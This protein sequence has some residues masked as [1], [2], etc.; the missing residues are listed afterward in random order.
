MNKGR[1]IVK[2]RK[3]DAHG[4]LKYEYRENDKEKVVSLGIKIANKKHFNRNTQRM[5][6]NKPNFEEIN[7]KIEDFLRKNTTYK[8]RQ[9]NNS[10]LIYQIENNV[11]SN[12]TNISTIRTYKTLAS[13]LGLFL[14]GTDIALNDID[15]NFVNRFKNYL[16][17]NYSTNSASCYFNR[18]K[19][20][21]RTI[22]LH[23]DYSFDDKIFYRNSIKSKAIEKDVLSVSE[24]QRLQNYYLCESSQRR[25]RLTNIR[26]LFLFQVLANGIR[27]SDLMTLRYSDFKIVDDEIFVDK[28]TIKNN[29]RLKFRM[30]ENMLAYV[31]SYMI[32]KED[33]D[34]ELTKRL[35]NLFEEIEYERELIKNY[36]DDVSKGIEKEDYKNKQGQKIENYLLGFTDGY[37]LNYSGISDALLL[38]AKLTKELLIKIID[39]SLNKKV[40][41]FDYLNDNLFG[42]VDD[43]SRLNDKQYYHLMHNRVIYNRHL[44]NIFKQIGVN[45]KVT[46]HT[47]RHTF[48]SL[49]TMTDSYDIME[50]SN[51]L[52]HSSIKV[53]ENY[54]HELENDKLG[55]NVQIEDMINKPIP[56]DKRKPPPN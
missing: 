17:K 46:S 43:F 36:F 48:T 35:S 53:T 24:L 4:Y 10:T 8:Q 44:K 9:S 56:F 1:I 13:R 42:D 27:L 3:K 39:T 52:T 18:L 22:Q 45:K 33:A 32:K 38:I 49:L 50:I 40:F 29:K 14:G 41:V 16:L 31:S 28:Q 2:S 11:I 30:T 26:G 51:A 25:Y 55:L 15:R 6:L 5:R 37:T 20:A 7:L 54:I 19:A 12:Y 21:L 34:V 23:S 47:S